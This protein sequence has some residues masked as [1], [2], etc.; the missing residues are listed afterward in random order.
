V[1]RARLI[2][3]EALAY[4]RSG[5]YATTRARVHHRPARR[6]DVGVVLVHGVGADRT[7]FRELSRALVPTGAWIDAFDYRTTT[8]FPHI[9]RAL[10]D[11][12]R[13]ARA[14]ADRLVVV[15]HSLGGVLLSLLLQ[16]DDPPPHVA[17]FVA[18]CAPLHGTTRGRFAPWRDVRGI[19]PDG[20]HTRRLLDTRERLHLW[21]RPI[22]TIGAEED[23]FVDPA[24]SAF[25]DGH[26]SLRLSGSGHVASLFDARV[27]AAV[28]DFV[29]SA[30]TRP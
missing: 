13:G 15:G 2:T 6:A 1:N 14:H 30:A 23:A 4:V 27:H 21:Q 8:P 22:L 25:L 3:G 11:A 29:R 18:I 7:Q 26:P 16:S 10:A 24:E 28:V 20:E 5:V 17:G 12:V 19:T 9:L